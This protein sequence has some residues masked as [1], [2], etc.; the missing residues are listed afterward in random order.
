VEIRFGR[1]RDEAGKIEPG[2]KSTI[3]VGTPIIKEANGATH[4]LTPMN[5]RL[6]NL[7][8]QAPIRL[9][10]AV[11]INGI[12]RDVQQVNIGNLPIM[13]KSKKCNLYENNIDALFQR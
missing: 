6:R 9:D 5:A 4:E 8:Y 10:F 7:R 13:I 12:E 11:T 2:T 3:S 1:K